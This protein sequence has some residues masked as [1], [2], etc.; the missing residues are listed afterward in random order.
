MHISAT[1]LIRYEE[2]H[3]RLRWW[4]RILNR[5]MTKPV[6][7]SA[8]RLCNF[9]DGQTS[10][11]ELSFRNLIVGNA[12]HKAAELWVKGGYKDSEVL[13][14]TAPAVFVSLEQEQ[15]IKQNTTLYGLQRTVYNRQPPQ[16]AQADFANDRAYLFDK[17]MRG[18]RQLPYIFKQ[19][20]WL[21]QAAITEQYIKVP[22]P[23]HSGVI[24]HGF[25]DLRLTA[26][27][28]LIDYKSSTDTK[29]LK[30]T[31]L[32]FYHY[33][34]ELTGDPIKRAYWVAPL[35]GEPVVEYHYSPQEKKRVKQLIS[36]YIAAQTSYDFLRQH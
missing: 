8:T 15:A 13:E 5:I 30:P 28:V 19:Q 24:L 32:A 35:T 17:Y 2:T 3:P 23:N 20:G 18:V 12:L 27:K 25:A 21:G 31:Q 7:I 33:M 22:D 10:E 26:L 1:K 36:D 29:W 16:S 14:R 11:F 6:K 9:E 4:Q 34:L